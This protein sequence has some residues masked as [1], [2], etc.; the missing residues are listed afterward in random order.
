M[1]TCVPY[2]RISIDTCHEDMAVYVDKTYTGNVYGYII[3][4]FVL[5]GYGPA[6]GKNVGVG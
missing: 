5:Y 6:K 3:L 1:L 2:L 4:R